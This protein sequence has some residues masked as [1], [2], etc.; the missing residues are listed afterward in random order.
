MNT[1]KT[2]EK[3]VDGKMNER[4]RTKT[5]A[6]TTIALVSALILFTLTVAPAMAAYPVHNINTSE[7]FSTI[8]AAIDDS[9]TKDGHTITVDAGVY[10]EN[11]KVTKSLT[12]KSTSGNPEDTIV[13]AKNS[14]DDIF[15]VTANYVN[16]TGFT[17]TVTTYINAG[18]YLKGADYCSISNIN[19]SNN[20]YGIYLY[21]SS[22]NAIINCNA[23]NNGRGIKL[24]QSSSNNIT[25]CNAYN[26]GGGIINLGYSSKNKI[27]NCNIYNNYFGI[28]LHDYSSNSDITNCNIHNNY[29][30]GIHLYQ[31]S[32]NAIINCIAYNN[33]LGIYLWRSSN[34]NITNCIAY[35][36]GAG[37]NLGHSSS[38]DITNCNAYNNSFGIYLYYSSNNNKIYLNNFINNTDNVYSDNVYSS[39][40]TNIW[41]STL[42]ITYTYNGSTYTNYMGNY[43]SDYKGSD[44]NGNG[45]G[46]TPYSINSDKDNY[47]LMQPF[48]NYFAQTLAAN[49]VIKLETLNL[50]SK[51]KFTAFIMLPDGYN[52]ADID[53]STVVCEVAPAV[54]GMVS[55]ED[56]GTYIAKFNRQDLIDVP[57]GDAVMMTV[58]G[59]MLTGETFEGIDT[60][61][62][63]GKAPTPTPTPPIPFLISGWVN[64]SVGDP[65]NNPIVNITNLNTSEVFL[66]ETNEFFS[67]YQVLTSSGNVNA[68][69]VL[70]FTCDGK[71]I[72]YT[73]RQ[74]EMNAGGFV[75]DITVEYNI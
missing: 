46:D 55:E 6:I 73:V 18:I 61:R 47:P 11:V 8:Q 24:C 21:Q 31:T 52:V 5:I 34:N 10:T 64:D 4:K 56:N 54:K 15:E 25:N 74:I 3:S 41:D 40:S 42:K 17:V 35:N 58:K 67:Y 66:G 53:I 29:W 72:C 28:H 36:N 22:N 75:Q 65:V 27:T 63:I 33:S 26:N 62:V 16:I 44:L 68:G 2:F 30:E 43:W 32:N 37:I 7:N 9:D 57:T 60:V 20:Y 23:Y 39:S 59:K 50:N 69:N 13:Q 1:N 70:R 71:S 49:I 48:E 45:I 14:N 12:I 19:V 51:G 38:N